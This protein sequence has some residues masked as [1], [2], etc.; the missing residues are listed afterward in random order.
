MKK[1]ILFI[2]GLVMLVNSLSYGIIIPLL[3]PYASKFGLSATGLSFLFASFSLAQFL[4]TPLIG[5][6]SDSY[7]RRP[8]L[9]LC[10]LGT[11]ISLTLFATAQTLTQL[12]IA[13][14]LDGITGGNNSVAQAIIA[15]SSSG[16][17]RAKAFGMLGAVMGL[18]FVVGPAVGGFLSTYSLSM[19]FWFGA[20]LALIGTI[21]GFFLLPETNSNNQESKSKNK[22]S[23]KFTYLWHA[24]FT[25]LVGVL[26]LLSFIVTTATNGFF[27]GFQAHTVDVL[28]L[29]TFQIGSLFTL[30]GFVNVLIQGFAL[31]HILKKFRS[32]RA[33]IKLLLVL[34][35][36]TMIGL[37]FTYTYTTFLVGILF[38]AVAS[39][40]TLPIIT[41]MISVRTKEEDQGSILGINQAYASLGQI[42][43]PMLAGFA[44]TFSTHQVF[45]L[46]ALLFFASLLLSQKIVGATKNKIDL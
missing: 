6:L 37:S 11:S 8:L 36:I 10:L 39:T 29:S 26:L 17:D 40:P 12:F 19:P 1:K 25:P 21:L 22:A 41:S 16:N 18:G 13:R 44:L 7:G 45:I 43:G 28:K 2:V 15:D 35:V 32:K 46:V 20:L 24:L 33:L 38:F 14:I 4:A 30:F 42:I 3:Y 23:F 31:K 34:S 27:I 9:L 5:R